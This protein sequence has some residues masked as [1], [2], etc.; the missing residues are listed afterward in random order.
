M[1]YEKAHIVGLHEAMR[2]GMWGVYIVYRL[3]AGTRGYLTPAHVERV[4]R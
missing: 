3:S 2:S 1:K 4:P